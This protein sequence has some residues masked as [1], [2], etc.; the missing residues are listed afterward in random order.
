[1]GSNTNVTVYY[2]PPAWFEEQLGEGQRQYLLD[3]LN[4]RDEARRRFRHTLEGQE[5]I[6]NEECVPRPNCVV[7]MSSDYAS[8][9]EHAI[10]NFVGL[11]R[12]LNPKHLLLHNPPE[13]VHTQL[14]RV[15]TTK[16]E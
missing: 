15:F 4:E 1:M 10:T 13:L 11:V 3:L 2:G 12:E 7:A 5:I 16:V 8:V 9:H 6:E 14:D